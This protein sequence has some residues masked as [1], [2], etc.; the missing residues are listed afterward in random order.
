MLYNKDWII[1]NLHRIFTKEDF[2]LNGCELINKYKHYK[3][4]I[5]SKRIEAKKR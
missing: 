2:R 3:S 1:N 4:L 5:K